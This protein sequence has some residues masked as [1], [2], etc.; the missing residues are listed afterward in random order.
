MTAT[1]YARST[2][3]EP[4][5]N[6][7]SETLQARPDRFYLLKGI[8]RCAY[9]GMSMWAQT[10]KSGKP[11]YRE[12]KASRSYEI[13][14]GGGS[15]KAGITQLLAEQRPR[16]LITDEIDKANS[17]DLST[18]LSLMESGLVSITKVCRQEQIRVKTWVFAGVN[19]PKSVAP[20]L[21]ELALKT[22]LVP[23]PNIPMKS[24]VPLHGRMDSEPRSPSRQDIKRKKDL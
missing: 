20:E 1:I 13:C 21:A 2:Q 16:Y 14:S 24:A 11:F 17:E 22:L 12:H 18:L 4:P 19:S 6:G 7:R 15:T 23:S 8:I 10:Y 5:I 3:V 9:C